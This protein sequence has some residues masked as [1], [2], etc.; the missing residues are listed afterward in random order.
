MRGA[1]SDGSALTLALA[2]RS[3]PARL[4]GLVAISAD[5]EAPHLGYWLGRPYWGAG[6]MGGATQALVHAYFAYAGGQ[7]PGVCGASGQPRVPARS[8]ESRLSLDRTG[9]EALPGARPRSGHG[10]I[11]P[12]PRLLVGGPGPARAGTGTRRRFVNGRRVGRPMAAPR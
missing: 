6:L 4:I 8:G 5:R 12:E 3:A 10:S 2:P 7:R 1:N 9:P 11:R